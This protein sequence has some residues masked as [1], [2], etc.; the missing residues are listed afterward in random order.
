MRQA[1][2]SHLCVASLRLSRVVSKVQICKIAPNPLRGREA[3]AAAEEGLDVAHLVD[4]AR[5]RDAVLQVRRDA[6]ARPVLA[7]HRHVLARL[8]PVLGVLGALGVE[9][10]SVDPHALVPKGRELVAGAHVRQHKLALFISRVGPVEERAGGGRGHRPGLEGGAR[11]GGQR[12]LRLHVLVPS[13]LAQQLQVG[14]ARAGCRRRHGPSTCS[15]H[16]PLLLRNASRAA[17]QNGPPAHLP[18]HP[19]NVLPT[20]AVASPER[21][22]SAKSLVLLICIAKW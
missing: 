18:A 16:P 3:V 5:V 20:A 17:Y 10:V 2:L 1:K 13:L 8:L 15:D 4:D 12:L 21:L 9:P 6:H 7:G 14:H 22:L 19:P 11:L